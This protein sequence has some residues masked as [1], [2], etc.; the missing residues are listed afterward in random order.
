MQ[1]EWRLDQMG[2]LAS[3][4]GH[5][6]L[7]PHDLYDALRAHD[8]LFYDEHDQ[9]WVVTGY[10][11]CV[12]ILT[13]ARFSSN[14]AQEPPC[15]A[16]H[17][18]EAALQRIVNNQITFMSGPPH[19]KARA[20]FARGIAPAVKRA[21]LLVRAKVAAI[22]TAALERNELNLVTD[23][24]APLALHMTADALGIPTTD[25]AQLAVLSAWSD[26]FGAVTSGYTDSDLQDVLDLMVYF[27]DLLA[28]KRGAPGEDLLTAMVNAPD[29]YPTDDDLIANAVMFFAAGHGTSR[30]LLGTGVPL[31]LP[32]WQAWRA[33]V[34]EDPGLI[35]L[36]VDE[37]LR[38]VTPPRYLVRIA[39]VDVD[40]SERFPGQH[41]IRRG[42]RVYLFLDAANHDPSKFPDPAAFCPARK[43]TSQLLFGV[44]QHTC[45]GAALARIEAQ[46]A[47]EMLFE[48][49]SLRAK[50]GVEPRWNANRDVGGYASFVVEV[51]S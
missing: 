43:P 15:A 32:D 16:T 18:A 44:G 17:P 9:C 7:V 6:V 37:M 38:V 40:L 46:T 45:P 41:A 28:R 33:R 2:T 49:P 27:R 34:H 29:A 13:D 39:A 48:L 25:T 10:D 30:K 1:V 36:L 35:R 21:P 24:S 14:L 31:L 4:T 8:A 20:A 12:A 26:T 22:L 42:D 3:F 50:A 19:R 11:A 47:L 23:L 5:A 51:V